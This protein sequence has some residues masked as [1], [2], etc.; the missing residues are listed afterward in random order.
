MPF[1]TSSYTLVSRVEDSRYLRFMVSLLAGFS[2]LALILASLG[3]RFSQTRCAWRVSFALARVISSL[4]FGTTAADPLTFT[5]TIA[6]L[7][8]VALIAVTSPHAAPR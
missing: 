1:I 7:G 6:V 3:V 8:L 2:I 5:V 4:L